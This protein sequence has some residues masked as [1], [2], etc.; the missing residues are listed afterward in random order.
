MRAGVGQNHDSR[1]THAAETLVIPVGQEPR[2][3]CVPP[4]GDP[5]AAAN[6][7]K[8]AGDQPRPRVPTRPAPKQRKSR[9]R[10]ASTK[11]RDRAAALRAFTVETAGTLRRAELLVWLAIFNCEFHGQSEIGYSRLCTITKLSR[12]HVGKAVASL[13]KK[14]LL[15][16][17]VRGRFQPTRKNTPQA[18]MAVLEDAGHV[19]RAGQA[20]IYRIYATLSKPPVSRN[21]RGKCA[22]GN[23]KDIT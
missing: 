13:V 12:R 10:L 18:M 2:R 20:S 15:E 8:A 17:V 21:T 3:P 23:M 1:A 11:L 22:P 16:V 9:H 7:Q 19:R 5:F 4:G 6:Y 14:D